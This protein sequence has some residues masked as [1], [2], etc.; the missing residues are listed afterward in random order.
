MKR[1][2]LSSALLLCLSASSLLMSC[3]SE[4]TEE[5]IVLSGQWTGN[6]GMYYEYE[7]RGYIY[8][9]NSYDSDIVF[10][11]DYDY[12]TH[13]YG[14]EVDYYYEGPYDR[15]SLRFDWEIRSGRIYLYYP[16]NS[17]YNATISNYRLSNNYFTGYFNGGGEMFSLR[18]LADFYNWSEYS[19]YGDWHCWSNSGWSWYSYSKTRSAVAD[20]LDCDDTDEGRIVGYGRSMRR[21]E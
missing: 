21:C 11:P 7:W 14:Y 18:K 6:F 15:M 5:S 13:G 1:Y 9:F 4:D 16:G 19:Y 8:T 2:L 20:S 3:M 17:C 12:A 10:Y